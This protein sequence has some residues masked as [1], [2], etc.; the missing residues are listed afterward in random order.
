MKTI[1][2][3]PGTDTGFAKADPSL[4]AQRALQVVCSMD[5]V[6]ACDAI[7]AAHAEPGGV[8]VVFEDARNHRIRGGRNAKKGS[9]ILQGV[10]A[11]KGHCKALQQ[12]LE[13]EGIPYT[14]VPPRR[15]ATKKNA[16][17]FKQI[18]GWAGRTN[19]H[20]RDAAMFIFGISLT[21]ARAMVQAWQ[22]RVAA[23]GK[24]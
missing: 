19:E 4:P 11:V 21:Q 3:D 10:G 24:R 20:G 23:A 5:L 15:R 17:L 18:T 22:Q 12:F 16:A 1:G 13:R 9:K 7:K 6:Q 2:I 8:L 14:T